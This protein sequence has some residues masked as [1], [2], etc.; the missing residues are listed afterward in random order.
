M[1]DGAEA[2]LK[3][4]TVLQEVWLVRLLSALPALC[5]HCEKWPP[6]Q[7]FNGERVFLQL[8]VLLQSTSFRD[9]SFSAVAG[10]WTSDSWP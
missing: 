7:R 6:S 2:R 5:S 8:D 10:A 9:Y 4:P 1:D 3:E